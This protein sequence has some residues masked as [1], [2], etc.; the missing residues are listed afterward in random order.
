MSLEDMSFEQRDQLALLMR[1]LS[2]NP[3]TRKEVLRLTK[4]IKPD[5]VIPELEIESTTKSYVE[6]LEQKLMDREAK[7]REQDALRDLESRRNRLMKKGLV[8]REED[9][10]EVEKIMLEK[11]ISNHESAA[12]YWQWMKQSA[13]PTPTGYNP[14]AVSKFDLGKYYKNPQAAARDEA[15][16]ALQ[17]L[18]KNTRPIGF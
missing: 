5:L 11:G 8:E 4:Q 15:A 14:S 10:E 6:K 3:A 16:K 7:D 1:E 13:T 9:I 18:R 17:E 12:E 2:D